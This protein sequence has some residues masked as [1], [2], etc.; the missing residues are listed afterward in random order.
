[1][2]NGVAP[3]FIFNFKKLTPSL[4]ESI[5]KIPVVAEVLNAIV[6]PAI[7]IY[8][9]EQLTGICVQSQDKNIDIETQLDTLTTGGDPKSNQR[10]LSSTIK[11]NMVANS[12]SIGLILLS[13]IC[14]L[15]FPKVTSK[16]YSITYLNGAQ[17]VFD[18]LLHSFSVNQSDQNDLAQISMEIMRPGNNTKVVNVGRA[19]NG[20]P[21]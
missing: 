16:E 19:P 12:N 8:L 1:M 9:D 4:T 21:A 10:A 6:L 14:D 18:G 5:S 15:V 7:P 17:T 2:L 11:I 13:A 3:I 20:V